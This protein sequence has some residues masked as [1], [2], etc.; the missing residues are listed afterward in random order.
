[1]NRI[2]PFL[3]MALTVLWLQGCGG[4]SDQIQT[5]SLEQKKEFKEVLSSVAKA[6]SSAESA[7]PKRR[8]AVKPPESPN[9]MASRLKVDS[10]QWEYPTFE[11][12]TNHTNPLASNTLID[13]GFKIKGDKCPITMNLVVNISMTDPGSVK[14]VVD[15]D[16]EVRDSQYRSLNDIDALT[17]K[18][19]WAI[20]GP[21]IGNPSGKVSLSGEGKGVLRSQRLGSL[22]VAMKASGSGDSQSFYT[23]S[24]TQIT[25]PTHVVELKQISRLENGKK[26]PQVEYFLNGQKLSKEEYQAYLKDGGV[27]F[28][29]AGGAEGLDSGE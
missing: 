2:Y 1:M 15:V 9:D 22:N 4:A 24:S 13:I 29:F 17:L 25:F 8:S 10:C 5:L 20:T 16:Y 18:S 12:P 7:N 19:N 21:G 28:T 3:A 14:G 26:E 11:T 6:T 23:E 27:A